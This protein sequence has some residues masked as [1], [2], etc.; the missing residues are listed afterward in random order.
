ME[1]LKVTTELDAAIKTNDVGAVM[2]IKG[3][4]HRSMVNLMRTEFPRFDSPLL[5]KC[6]RPDLY[7]I[8][9]HPRGYA[10]LGELPDRRPE[11]RKLKKR[12]YGRLTEE[13]YAALVAYLSRD[14]FKDVQEF[15]R[16][17]VQ[18]YIT[19]AAQI[20]GRLENGNL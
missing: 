15:I 13:E 14:G 7:G 5:S 11:N 8:V 19:D 18:E 3:I 9:L 12:I 17:K 1:Q 16:A 4:S 2:Q 6:R 20:Y 10:L